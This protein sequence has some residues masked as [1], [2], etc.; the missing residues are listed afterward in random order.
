MENHRFVRIWLEL[1]W[2]QDKVLTNFTF[3]WGVINTLLIC[4]WVVVQITN[5]LTI[6]TFNKWLEQKRIK[7]SITNFLFIIF[8]EE[9]LAYVLFIWKFKLDIFRIFFEFVNLSYLFNLLIEFTYFILDIWNIKTASSENIHLD[10][11][12][13]VLFF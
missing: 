9:V 5:F 10:Y 8:D 4:Y 1:L 3:H 7:L 12:S 6:F 13:S 11:F 2:G